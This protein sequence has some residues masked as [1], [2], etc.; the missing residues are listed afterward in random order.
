MRCEIC[1]EPIVQ[2]PAAAFDP[3]THKRWTHRHGDESCGT[4]DGSV[5]YPS[6]TPDLSQ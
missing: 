4:G 1:H 3:P 6:E 5:A 2:A